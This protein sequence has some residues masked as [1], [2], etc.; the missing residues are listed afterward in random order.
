[1]TGNAARAEAEVY[2]LRGLKCPLPVMKARKRLSKMRGGAALWVE[3][4]DP[5]AV[6]DIPHF[7]H[8]DGHALEASE[9]IEGGHRFLI[10]KKA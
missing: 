9:R 1:M 5:L 2:D 7:C 3:T 6:I 10:R 8:E 4:T